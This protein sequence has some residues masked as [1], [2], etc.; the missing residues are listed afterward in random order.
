MTN[1]TSVV[2]VEA[3]PTPILEGSAVGLVARDGGVF[4]EDKCISAPKSDEFDFSYYTFTVDAG[5]EQR[6]KELGYTK[7]GVRQVCRSRCRYGTNTENWEK[8]P[9]VGLGP[10]YTYKF[11]LDRC[12]KGHD[13]HVKYY[14]LY[15]CKEDNS[16]APESCDQQRNICT[17]GD[18][19]SVN[20][21]DPEPWVCKI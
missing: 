8:V 7:L 20:L 14:T 1:M 12:K 19:K 13:R 16:C 2:V 5:M 11:K 17:D 15:P 6:A 9:I 18:Q 10:N 4:P 21:T 3:N